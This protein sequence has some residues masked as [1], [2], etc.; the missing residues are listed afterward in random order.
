[1]KTLI[2][3]LVLQG[4]AAFDELPH[5]CLRHDDERDTCYVMATGGKHPFNFARQQCEDLAGGELPDADDEGELVTVAG[6]LSEGDGRRAWVGAHLDIDFTWKWVAAEQPTRFQGCYDN[7]PDATIGMASYPSNRGWKATP[8]SCIAFCWEKGYS[9]AAVCMQ[10]QTQTC[11]CSDENRKLLPVPETQCLVPC[12]SDVTQHCATQ[13]R[14]LLFSATG[15]DTDDWV[16]P[17]DQGQGHC[18]LWTSAGWLKAPCLDQHGFLCQYDLGEMGCQGAGHQWIRGTCLSRQRDTITWLS[19]RAQCRSF[20]G[21]LLELDGE[22]NLRTYDVS[23]PDGEEE[24]WIGLTNRHWQLT[25]GEPME[26]D[27]WATDYPRYQPSGKAESCAA[28]TLGA[29][30]STPGTPHRLLNTD[31]GGELEVI[32]AIRDYSM[33]R[34]TWSSTWASGFSGSGYDVTEGWD[35]RPERTRSPMTTRKPPPGDDKQLMIGVAVGASCGALLVILGVVVGCAVWRCRTGHKPEGYVGV[36]PSAPTLVGARSKPVAVNCDKEGVGCY[37][38]LAVPQVAIATQPTSYDNLTPRGNDAHDKHR[39]QAAATNVN[40][41]DGL[42]GP[43]ALSPDHVMPVGSAVSPSS[44]RGSESPSSV[45]VLLTPAQTGQKITQGD[46]AFC[47]EKGYSLAAGVPATPW[48]PP[49]LPTAD[50]R[51]P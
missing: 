22:I 17:E 36:T 39:Q 28:M 47:W 14:L 24:W 7:N 20:G 8:K 18:G 50:G 3:V 41:S 9:L 34:I 46:I 13:D 33:N 19:A 12:L 15:S 21:D 31:C 43:S 26:K 23:D 1:M 37:E 38:T 25:S 10:A 5:G 16:A 51:Q 11:G 27:L 30:P 42:I 6:V 44:G 48:T 40:P 35:E 4:V 45:S 32:C 29:A 49:H 2:L